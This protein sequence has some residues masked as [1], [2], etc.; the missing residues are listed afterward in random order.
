MS[1]TGDAQGI[2]MIDLH[3]HILPGI[4]DGAPDMDTALAMARLTVENG[5][6]VLACTPHILP[7]VWNN[8]GQ[9]IR[10]AVARLQ[11]AL[12]EAG[13]PLRLVTGADVHIAPD[14]V[15]GLKSGR[16][17]SLHDTRYLLIETP[18][19]VAPPN[20]DALC[21]D[22]LSAGYVPV[23]THPERL[24]WIDRHYDLFVQLV[25]A[26]V[27]MQITAGSIIGAFGKSPQYWGERMLEDGL[28]HILASDAHNTR[29]R[30]PVLAQGRDAAA[31]IVGDEEAHNL[32]VARP[33]GMLRNL[34][35][36]ALPALAG[37][38]AVAGGKYATNQNAYRYEKGKQYAGNFRG[39]RDGDFSGRLRR[40]F[41]WNV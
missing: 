33:Y 13:I 2:F 29:R 21:F 27:L 11:T 32:V 36:N 31:A 14:L 12:D 20:L 39:S 28:V 5:V 15:A 26:G 38:D 3:C 25:H 7:G 16:V 10:V 6:K 35:P 22:L 17:L 23:L 30:G 8:T 34:L 41:G 4:D 1:G 24:T 19:H 9:E 18:H 37:P 40:F